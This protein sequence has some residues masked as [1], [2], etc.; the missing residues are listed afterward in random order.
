MSRNRKLRKNLAGQA[1]ALREHGD[2]I[3]AE[4]AQAGPNWPRIDGWRQTIRNI[5]RIIERLERRRKR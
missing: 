5:E 4:L 3:Q 1:R 2:K